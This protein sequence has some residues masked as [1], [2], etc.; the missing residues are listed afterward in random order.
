MRREN[1]RWPLR[2]VA[3]VVGSALGV[4]GNVLILAS[5]DGGVWN[6]ILAAAVVV[7]AAGSVWQLR[8]DAQRG[9][10]GGDTG[11]SGG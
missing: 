11:S 8:R 6:V 2:V 1:R 3:I 7:I 5:G 9:G 10:R 4:I